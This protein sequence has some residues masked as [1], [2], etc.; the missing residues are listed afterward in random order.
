M[1]TLIENQN[2]LNQYFNV[3]VKGIQYTDALTQ[4]RILSEIWNATENAVNDVL[5][6][7]NNE[8][9]AL[10]QQQINFA[11]VALPG[12]NIEIVTQIARLEQEMEIVVRLQ[13]KSKGDSMA[14]AGAKLVYYVYNA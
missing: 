9:A 7:R 11:G 1:N 2:T 12:D 14:I 3:S 10:I 4:Q 6:P 13:K 8:K 5:Q